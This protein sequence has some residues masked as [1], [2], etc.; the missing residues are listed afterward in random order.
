MYFLVKDDRKANFDNSYAWKYPMFL[1]FPFFETFKMWVSP[2]PYDAAPANN[3]PLPRTQI[4][5]KKP[6]M[7]KIHNKWVQ[8]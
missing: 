4:V 5:T 1:I 7:T 3:T 2:V 8:N 6:K